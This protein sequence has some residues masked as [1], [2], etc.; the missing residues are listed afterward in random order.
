[1]SV[2]VKASGEEIASQLAELLDE[3]RYDEV[4]NIFESLDPY[5]A[6]SV[7]IHLGRD[8]RSEL[9]SRVSLNNLTPVLSKM[10]DEI[11]YQLTL[12]RG[13]DDLAKVLSHLPYDEIADVMLK[14]TPRQRAQLLSLLPKESAREVEKLLKYHPESVGGVMTTQV[15]IF[16]KDMTVSE[17]R[18]IYVTRD[19]AGF[20]DKH[21]YIYV[22][23]E[24]GRLY[25]WVEVKSFLIK[26]PHIKL[27]ECSQKPPATVNVNMDREVAARI[28]VRYDLLEVPVVDDEGRFLGVVTL[29]DVLDITVGELSEDLL[30]YGGYFEA[31]RGSYIAASPL[32]LALR[33]APMII[34]LYLMDSITG[35]IVASFISTIE[36]FAILAAFLPMLSDNSGN[37]GSQASTIVLRGLVL[38]ELRPTYKDILR[39]LRKEFAVTSLMLTILMPVA[40]T[41]GFAVSFVG[42]LTLL[43]ALKIALVVSL[44][45]IV[46]C[47]I[48]DIVGALLPVMLAK[49]RVDP[50]VVS[51]PLITTI[52]DIATSLSYFLVATYLL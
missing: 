14:L 27:S 40:F 4:L 12:V 11:F 18:D 39:V 43:G 20:Y 8:Y 22:V 19:K 50:A 24:K 5:T 36:R 45:L 17:A 51:A 25:G 21:H 30:K 42:G 29:D 28:A 13:L 26:P 47:Y 34:Y 3:D 15:P 1:M 10:P 38:G 7:L 6:L 2:S 46:S 32:K 31:L 41:I 49:M 37:I 16:N 33:R 44:A 52:A 23:D 48:A 35:S 9:L